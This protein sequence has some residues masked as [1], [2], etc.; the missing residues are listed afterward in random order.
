MGGERVNRRSRPG[1]PSE[2]EDAPVPLIRA[3]A[4]LAATAAE[5]AQG[6][7]KIAVL[8]AAESALE[9]NRKL[10]AQYA[11]ERSASV[12]IIHVPQVWTLF[13]SG[14]MDA[15]F[16]AIASATKDAYAAGASVVAF[17]HPWM[18]R[19]AD[20][21]SQASE[22]KRPLDSA[23]AALNTVMRRLNQASVERR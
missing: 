3:N 19:A 12:D 15:C 10:F 8:C 16:A 13:R 9:S 2:T 6:G 5:A 17:A 23:R 14:E 1:F 21:A 4:A 7:G 20:L 11:V 18:A 22:D